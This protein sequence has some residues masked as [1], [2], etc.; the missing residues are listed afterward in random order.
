MP[1]AEVQ[2]SAIVHDALKSG[3]RVFIPYCY[4]HSTPIVGQ[5]GSIM[6]MLELRDVEDYESLE[7]DGW[8][9]PTPGEDSISKRRNCF[10]GFGK[11]ESQEGLG[12][13]EDELDLVVTPGLG[14][15]RELARIGRGMGFYDSFFERC[16]K[17]S[18]E[19]KIPWK[20]EFEIVFCFELCSR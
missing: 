7:P 1:S 3:K 4:K 6:D 17:F 19:G 9:I 15:D 14:F 18:K 11:S 12:S 16:G 13:E 2:T 8:G 10:G 5:T 20:G